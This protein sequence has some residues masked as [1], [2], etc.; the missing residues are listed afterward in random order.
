MQEHVIDA[1]GNLD[2]PLESETVNDFGQGKQNTIDMIANWNSS[3]YGSQNANSTYKD[4]WGVIQTA[5]GNISDPTWF[6][7][8]KSE[9]AAFGDFAYTK[10]GVDTENY[11][12]YGLQGYYWSSAQYST[13][14]AYNAGFSS[15]YV[16][17]GSVDNDGT[18]VRLSAT[19]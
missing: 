3:G 11:V 12:N 2:N 7:P 19:F 17:D 16:S 15:G 18:C 10:M 9:W 8:S 13:G 4:M 14:N 1:Y 5:V 6:V